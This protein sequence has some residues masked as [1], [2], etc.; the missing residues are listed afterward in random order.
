[1]ALR[2]IL[3]CLDDTAAGERRLELALNIA[4]ANK[5]YLTA[6]YTVPEASGPV[7]P[8]VGP[9]LPP[10]VLGPVSPEGAAAIGGHS[11][12]VTASAGRVLPGT[13]RAAAIERRFRE[14]LPSRELDGEWRLLARIE[15][16]ELIALAKAAD[17]VVL[18]Q[19]S[20]NDPDA[21]SWLRPDD[22]MIDI[23]RPVLVVPCAGIFEHVGRRVLIAWDGTREANRALHD[24]LPLIDSAEAVTVMHV[25]ARQGDLDRDR[26]SLDHIVRHLGRHG[27]SAQPEASLSNGVAISDFLLSRAADLGADMIV[28]GAY[29]HS[30]LRESLLGGV[31]R[32]LLDHMTVPVLMSH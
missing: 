32:G 9:G 23:G 20:D 28:A 19:Y 29:H 26:H 16:A 12:V 30:P 21:M 18:G 22:V 17:L 25:G 1:M 6:V 27:I 11:S 3:V 14:E 13:E 7:V 2:D 8:P 24:A 5:A 10:T 15:L 31:S 4:Q